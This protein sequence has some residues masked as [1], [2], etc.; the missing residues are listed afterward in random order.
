MARTVI[1]GGLLVLPDSTLRADVVIEGEKITQIASHADVQPG[2][3]VINAAA[4]LVMPGLIDAHTHIQLDTGIFKTADNWEIGTRAAAAGGVTTVIDFAN[5][6]RRASFDE[7]LAARQTDAS[8]SLIDYTFHFVMLDPPHDA[9]QL[10]ADLAHLAELGISSLKLFTTYR[11]NY[12]LDD[13]ALFNL[14]SAMP[15]GMIAM[16]HAENDSIVSDATQ[17]LVETGNTGWRYH[18]KGRPPEAEI[19]A[20][21][22]VVRLGSFPSSY[23]PLYIA[24]CSTGASVWDIQQHREA[25]AIVYCETCPQYLLLDESCYESSTPER[26][27]LQPPLRRDQ[28]A[29]QLRQYVQ[30]GLINVISTDTCDYTTDQKRESPE[31]TKTPGGLPGIETLLPLMYTLFCDELEEPVENVIRLMTYNPAQIFGL[32]PQ[33]GVLQ[34][35]SDADITLYDPAP[36]GIIQHEDLHYVAGYSPYDGMRVKGKVR[37]TISRGEIIYNDEQF[38]AQPGRG[39][40]VRSSIG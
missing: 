11:P 15:D 38:P 28:D 5:Q 24:H 37:M 2:D 12:Y 40:F 27:I 17:R 33:K 14:F 31:F 36:E 16:V 3:Q 10:R 4:L 32:L 35:G 7:A 22:R 26:F 18:A 25:G 21:N 34:V 13:A 30:A 29:E 6:I 19:E 8:P 20:I 9:A 39:K 1:Q 23:V